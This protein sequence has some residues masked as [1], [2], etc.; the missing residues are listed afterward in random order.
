MEEKDNLYPDAKTT[1]N[2]SNLRERQKGDRKVIIPTPATKNQPRMLIQLPVRLPPNKNL[3]GK[4]LYW[5][6]LRVWQSPP[7]DIH[8]KDE[9]TVALGKRWTRG[10]INRSLRRVRGRESTSRD[11][12][13]TENHSICDHRGAIN[14]I[15]KAWDF[16]T[17][18][19]TLLTRAKGRKT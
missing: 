8:T 1:K 4:S 6:T 12:I 19:E 17:L 3:D 2:V 18:F 16:L 14:V 13:K 7:K 15:T 10:C 11:S 9:V 5:G